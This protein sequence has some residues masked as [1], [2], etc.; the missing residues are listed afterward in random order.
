MKK[1]LLLSLLVSS[2]L[3]FSQEELNLNKYKYIVIENLFE[4]S[5]TFI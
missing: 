5:T 4:N 3:T 1:L 2:Q